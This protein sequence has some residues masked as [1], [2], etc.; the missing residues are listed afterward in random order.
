MGCLIQLSVQG[1]VSEKQ[2]K[3]I[4]A[5]ACNLHRLRRNCTVDSGLLEIRLYNTRTS[6]QIGSFFLKRIVHLYLWSS[7]WFW[8]FNLYLKRTLTLNLKK[9]RKRVVSFCNVIL[10]AKINWSYSTTVKLCKTFDLK[11]TVL[12]IL[13]ENL[14]LREST[15]H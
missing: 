14:S 11:I 4:H 8:Y 6:R 10:K 9:P 12:V 5:A 13:T 2:K 7:M 15:T 1:C 3:I